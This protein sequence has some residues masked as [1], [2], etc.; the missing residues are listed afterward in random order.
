MTNVQDEAQAQQI[1]GVLSALESQYGVG[2]ITSGNFMTADA[3]DVALAT[4]YL[5]MQTL[6]GTTF[7]PS[8]TGTYSVSVDPNADDQPDHVFLRPRPVDRRRQRPVRGRHGGLLPNTGYNSFA[9]L[10]GSNPVTLADIN[11]T[12]A[13]GSADDAIACRRRC[14]PRTTAAPTRCLRPPACSATATCCRMSSGMRS[15]AVDLR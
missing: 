12:T 7:S 10:N 14:R 15:T 5:A 11:V 13:P 6:L 4:P 1:T 9:G 8:G 3:S 2:I